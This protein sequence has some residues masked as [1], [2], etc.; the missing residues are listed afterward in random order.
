MH[1][2]IIYNIALIVIITTYVKHLLVEY[3]I[4]IMSRKN[5]QH[6]LFST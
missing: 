6:K 3:I 1:Y 4:S 5:I 2:I